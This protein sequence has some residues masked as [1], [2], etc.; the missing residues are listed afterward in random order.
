V[1]IEDLI[2]Q[3]EDE[4]DAAQARQR[5]ATAEIN[6]I[7]EAA[8]KDQRKQLTDE[9]D[10]RATELF[11][12]RELASD[13]EGNAERKL[14]KASKIKAEEEGVAR[15]AQNHAPGADPPHRTASVASLRVSPREGRPYSNLSDGNST[16]FVRKHD[17]RP[18]ALARGE[19]FGDHE[20]GQEILAADAER[21]RHIVG[22]HGGIGNMVRSM[23]T[24]S[25]SATVPQVWASDIIDRARNLAAVTKAGATIIPMDSLQLN[26]GRLTVDP[27][28]SFHTEGAAITAS[29]PTFDSVTLVAKTIVAG[30][31][32]GSWEWFQDTGVGGGADELVSNALAQAIALGIDQACL[33]GGVVAGGEQAASPGNNLLPTGGLPTPPNPKGVL[34]TLLSS[35]TS[36]VLTTTNGTVQTAASFYKEIIDTIWFPRDFNEAPNALLWPSRLA[37]IYAEACDTQNNPMRVPPDVADID[38]YVTNQIPSG[39]TQGTGTL[40]SD[41]FVGDWSQLLLGVRLDL[42]V[43]VL[44]EAYAGNGQ[45]GILAVSRMDCACARPRAFA[46]YRGLR[47][48]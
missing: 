1:N 34:A 29:D 3:L 9:E 35:A 17:G 12:D 2:A 22:Y 24:S 38:K 33:F 5:R 11:R 47:S 18:A 19:R 26:I 20:I 30:P 16:L 41:V 32:I 31:V 45:F 7:L 44:Q 15:R 6:A 10:R 40:M 21:D 25:G 28:A 39:F 13:D 42:Q 36:S 14:A 27:T 37:R 23:S 8:E 48:F 43:Q 46:V 4:R